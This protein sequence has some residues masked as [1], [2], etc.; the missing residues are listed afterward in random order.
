MKQTVEE[1]AKEARMTSAET[2]TTYGTHT[3][4]LMI[5]HIYLM[6]KLQNLHL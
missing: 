1:A 3:R 5:L 6:M 4:H 2:L